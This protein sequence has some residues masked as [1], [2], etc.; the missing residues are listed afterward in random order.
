MGEGS[1]WGSGQCEGGVSVGEGSVVGAVS[2]REGSVW[3]R[4]QCG[5]GVSVGRGQ[6]GGGAK[7]LTTSIICEEELSH[8]FQCRLDERDVVNRVVGLYIN[9]LQSTQYTT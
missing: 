9:Q 8:K 4:G 3:G 7:G 5:G 2:V 1:V 6:C